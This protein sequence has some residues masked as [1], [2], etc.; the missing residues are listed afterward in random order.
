M[1]LS[2]LLVLVMTLSLFFSCSYKEGVR[3]DASVSYLFFSGNPYEVTVSVN[4]GTKFKPEFDKDELYRIPSGKSIIRV[5]RQNK[6]ILEKEIFVSE[7]ISKEIEVPN[8]F[9]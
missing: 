3:N 4:E 1:K 2:K 6:L 5:Y 7:G 8:A 9:R